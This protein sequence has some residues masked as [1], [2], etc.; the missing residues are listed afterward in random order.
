MS[1]GGLLFVLSAPSGTGKSTVI[2]EV[3]L[4]IDK[5]GYCVSHT[6]RNPRPGEKDGV[7]YHFVTQSR[8]KEMI[9]KG[10]FVEWATVY[11]EYYGTAV[12]SLQREL[13]KGVDVILDVD[14][15]GAQNIRKRFAD[16]VLIFLIPPSLKVLEQ[17]LRGRGTDS[18]QTIAKRLEKAVSEVKESVHYDYIV[19]NDDLETAVGDVISIIR[20]ERCKTTRRL[21]FIKTHF[22]L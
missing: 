8:F 4:R 20:A 15:V 18:T 14:P 9:D 1:K 10:A 21:E 16:A 22:Q 3:R 12:D 5:L 13:D 7:H 17:R 6:T 19:I 2:K 11:G